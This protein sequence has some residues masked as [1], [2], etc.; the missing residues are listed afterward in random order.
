M[1]I[2][3]ALNFEDRY[4]IELN[5][6]YQEITDKDLVEKYYHPSY[7]NNKGMKRGSFSD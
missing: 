6:K 3:K 4:F 1:K 7:I 5:V 2:I